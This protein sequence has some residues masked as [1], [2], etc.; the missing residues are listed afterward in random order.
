MPFG[1]QP[2]GR[3]W[4]RGQ[5]FTLTLAGAAA[6][7]ERQDAV[8]S[9]RASGR[10]ALDSALAA[11]AAPRGLLP[12]DGVILPEL[13]GQRRGLTELSRALESAGIE[14]DEVRAA[15]DRLVTAGMVE[16]IPLASQQLA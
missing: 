15:V 12:G 7:A 10:A 1:K 2:T 6:E 13:R 11:W 8:L 4:A 16:A 3:R 5:K 14:P 9:A